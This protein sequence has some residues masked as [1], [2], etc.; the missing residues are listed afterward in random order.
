MRYDNSTRPWAVN[1]VKYNSVYKISLIRN[2]LVLET[3]VAVHMQMRII[4]VSADSY[5]V[6]LVCL[7]IHLGFTGIRVHLY[8]LKKYPECVEMSSY[9]VN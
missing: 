6:G 1:Y 8:A 5:Y 3:L 2:T 4:P 9:N 7:R